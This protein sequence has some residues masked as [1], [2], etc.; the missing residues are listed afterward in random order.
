MEMFKFHGHKCWASTAGFRA[1]LVALRELGVKRTGSSGELH[2][3]VEVGKNHGAQCFT[4][5]VQC[6]TGCTFGKDNIEKALWGKLAITLI[7]K[8]KERSVRISYKSTR[9]KQITESAFMKKRALG[10]PPTEIP[11]KE[12][13]EMVD[14]IWEAPEEEILKVEEVKPCSWEDYGEIMGMKPC[15]SC[16]ELVSVAYLRVVGDR[17]MC[18]PCAGYE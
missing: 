2:C 4:D 14:I 1:G 5:G 12:A 16:G 11:E 18:I 17:H 6:S 15:D 13:L 8:Q 3:I 10:V 7:D 9:N